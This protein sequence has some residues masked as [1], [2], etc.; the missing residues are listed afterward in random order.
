MGEDELSARWEMKAVRG[1]GM[2]AHR[3]EVCVA[4]WPEEVYVV[5]SP[6]GSHK[7]ISEHKLPRNQHQAAQPC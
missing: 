2:W 3:N 5:P 1:P 4:V 6:I 7:T